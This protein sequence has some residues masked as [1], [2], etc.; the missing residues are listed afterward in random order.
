M[1]HRLTRGLLLV[2]TAGALTGCGSRWAYRQ[3]QA[4]AREGNWDM[5][6]ARLT[7]ALQKDPENI[8]FRIA[9]DQARVQASRQHAELGRK[10]AAAV[11][12]DQAADELEIASKYDP[13]NQAVT[14]ELE[15]IRERIKQRES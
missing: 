8:R 15:I 12:L 7:R 10:H 9:L 6:V 2:L 14:E 5:A 3:A 4:E 11:E 13:A 1:T